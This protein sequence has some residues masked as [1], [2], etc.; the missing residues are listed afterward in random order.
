MK[1]KD[2]RPKTNS[3]YEHSAGGVIFRKQNDKVE[4]LLLKDKNDV[5]SFPK[6]LIEDGEKLVDTAKREISEEVGLTN[7]V[8]VDA[9]DSIGYFYRFENNLIRKKVDFFL[10]R[11]DG[12]KTPQPLFEEGISDVGWFDPNEALSLIGYAKTNKAILEKA[13]E[14]IL[15]D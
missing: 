5:W 14:K 11:Y 3:K 10:F 1:T 8:L 7:L 9:L 2:Q 6:G 12:N 13:I 15:S 4:I